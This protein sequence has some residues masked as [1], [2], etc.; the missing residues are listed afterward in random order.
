VELFERIARHC[1]NYA[2]FGPLLVLK[3]YFTVFLPLEVRLQIFLQ[4]GHCVIISSLGTLH[5]LVVS[6]L[7]IEYLLHVVG[8]PVNYAFSLQLFL[9]FLLLIVLIDQHFWRLQ[10]NFLRRI[11]H[12]FAWEYLHTGNCFLRF[13]APNRL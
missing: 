9:R 1:T 13:V 10:D 5:R 4:G 12:V 7:V 8:R 2:Q 11:V 3:S 6:F